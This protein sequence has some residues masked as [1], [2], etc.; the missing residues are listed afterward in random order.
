MYGS[1]MKEW[2]GSE[3]KG[4]EEEREERGGDDKGCEVSRRRK[5]A[6]MDIWRG[7]GW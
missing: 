3:R 1:E 4:K 7:R 6:R 2:Y 5:G